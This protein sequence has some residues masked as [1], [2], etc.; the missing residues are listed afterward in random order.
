MNRNEHLRRLARQEFDLLVIG[1]GISGACIAHDA[2]LRG[3]SVALLERRDFGGFTSAASS[4]LLHGGIRYLP[5]AQLWK[6]RESGREQRIMQRLAPHLLRWLPFLIPTEKGSFMQGALPL[7]AAMRIYG[8]CHC[9]FS[10]LPP[11]APLGEFLPPIKAVRVAPQLASIAKLSGAQVLNESHMHSSERMTLA[12][13]K[14]AASNGAAVANYAEAVS[15][16]S[17]RD[18]V[19]GVAVRDALSGKEFSV[20]ARMTVNSSGPAAQSLNRASPSLQLRLRKEITGFA[21]GVHLVTR[22]IHPDYAL[23]L[24]TREKTEGFVT[25]GGRHFFIIP[26]RGRSLIGTTNTPFKGD[27]DQLRVTAEDVDEFLADI[28]ETLPDLGLRRDEVYYAY[29]GIYPLT[30]R[31]IDPEKYQA[32]GDYQLVDH[33]S[34]DGVAGLITALGA[35]YTTARGLAE[36]TVDLAVRKLGCPAF[37]CRTAVTPLLEGGMTN[38]AAFIARKQEQYSALLT[39][40]MAEHLIRYHGTGIDR[41]ME[42]AAGDAELLKPLS[43]GVSVCA[44]EVLHAAR[45]EMAAHLDDVVFRRTGMGTIGCPDEAALNRAAAIMA[46]EL[47]WDEQRTAAEKAAVL[48]RYAFRQQV[49]PA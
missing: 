48:A 43:P 23:A 37:P 46:A 9:G 40:E 25:R 6:V 15:Y 35:K 20:A 4:K 3:L 42:T 38:L 10:D 26:W 31:V 21:R 39:K 24:T 16:L 41:V 33:H 44:A 29:V 32:G 27:F 30:V 14:T 12:F 5:Q 1:G 47:D 34:S 11:G 45:K 19:R 17:S 7:Q 36:K 22:Q 2:A 13:I 18:R 28:N 8:L 49:S